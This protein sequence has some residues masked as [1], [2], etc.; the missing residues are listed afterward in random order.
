MASLRRFAL[1]ADAPW[2]GA[3]RGHVTGRP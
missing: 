1:A 2:N 3:R